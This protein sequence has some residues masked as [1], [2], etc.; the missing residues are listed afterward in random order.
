[1]PTATSV[2]EESSKVIL[3][4]SPSAI[5]LGWAAKATFASGGFSSALLAS[6]ITA[7][8][9]TNCQQD[10]CCIAHPFP[11]MPAYFIFFRTSAA[12]E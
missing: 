10:D 2:A 9:N 3:T 1:M 11:D 8:N 5:A 12:A 7:N 4:R 6:A